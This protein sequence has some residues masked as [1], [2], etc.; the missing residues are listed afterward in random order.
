MLSLKVEETPVTVPDTVNM[1]E[2]VTLCG[3]A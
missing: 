1:C 2:T 3:E